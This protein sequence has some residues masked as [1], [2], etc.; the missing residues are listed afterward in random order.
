MGAPLLHTSSGWDQT[1]D[2]PDTTRR[3][4]GTCVMRARCGQN[5]DSVLPPDQNFDTLRLRHGDA[6]VLLERRNHTTDSQCAMG[7][8]RDT[9][10]M[11]MRDCDTSVP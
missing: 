2:S 6:R 5:S 8:P 4:R 1:T 7:Q 9:R 3:Q 11:R 10:A